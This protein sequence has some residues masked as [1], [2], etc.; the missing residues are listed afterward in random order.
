MNKEKS[1]EE[2]NVI[3]FKKPRLAVDNTTPP[4]DWLINLP[5]GTT[6]FASRKGYPYEELAFLTT[7][8][9]KRE[10]L[11]ELISDT[12]SLDTQWQRWVISERYCKHWN[13][14]EVVS[15]GSGYRSD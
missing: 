13:C 15:Y 2:E 6:F 14:F 3:P 12:L 7:I 1:L 4:V 5:I 11:V 8:T 9:D 10:K